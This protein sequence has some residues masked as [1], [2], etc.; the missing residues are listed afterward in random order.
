MP[1]L[2]Q[3]VLVLNQLIDIYLLVLFVYVISSWFPQ[4]R[5]SALGNILGQLSE[6]FLSLF[7]NILPPIGGLD[8]SPMLAFLALKLGQYLLATLA[9]SLSLAGSLV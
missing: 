6:P 9:S 4:L 2:I 7:H 1:I 8:F 5:N 3:L